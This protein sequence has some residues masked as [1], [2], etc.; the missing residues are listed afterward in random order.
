MKGRSRKSSGVST[1]SPNIP[2]APGR[3]KAGDIH[4][5]L[6]FGNYASNVAD[7]NGVWYEADRVKKPQSR[8]DASMIMWVVFR[9]SCSRSMRCAQ[10]EGCI[11]AIA[12]MLAMLLDIAKRAADGERRK[13]CERLGRIRMSGK[14][15][16]MK[17]LNQARGTKN[18]LNILTANARRHS[19]VKG[20]RD[21]IYKC[22]K[23]KNLKLP[24]PIVV[25]WS[26][27]DLELV[28]LT[29]LEVHRH[30]KAQRKTA[31][32][33]WASRHL[34]RT[35]LLEPNCSRSKVRTTL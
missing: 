4:S 2:L 33:R 35:L 18:K 11:Y 26:R 30:D 22:K 6:S 17:N 14:C 28:L 5:C 9:C 27:D 10:D 1:P 25:R 12:R 32:P 20:G 21:G 31:F 16:Q 8:G 19:G 34:P 24:S 15:N 3:S 7:A 29:Q 13:T 23:T